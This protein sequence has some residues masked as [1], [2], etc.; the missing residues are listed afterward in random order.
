MVIVFPIRKIFEHRGLN[1][2]VPDIFRGDHKNRVNYRDRNELMVSDLDA[3][4]ALKDRSGTRQ[5]ERVLCRGHVPEVRT[6]GCNKAGS[7]NVDE[8]CQEKRKRETRHTSSADTGRG[9]LMR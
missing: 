1:V 4:K 8:S 9:Q 5:W 6:H 7:D 3:R 2:G